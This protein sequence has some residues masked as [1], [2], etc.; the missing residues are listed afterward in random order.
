MVVKTEQMMCVCFD[1]SERGQQVEVVAVGVQVKR[2][3][4]D[5][6][7]HNAV[8]ALFS[9]SELPVELKLNRVVSPHLNNTTASQEVLTPHES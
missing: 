8:P 5:S 7:Q 1:Y 3:L 9:K 4:T 2:L 6:V